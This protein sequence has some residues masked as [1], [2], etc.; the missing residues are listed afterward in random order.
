ML[1]DIEKRLVF[2]LSVDVDEHC[3]HL[4]QERHRRRLSVN[5]AGAFSIGADGA[6]NEQ[7]VILCGIPRLRKTRSCRIGNVGKHSKNLRLCAARAHKIAPHALTEHGV[8][9]VDED[10]FARAR[11]AGQ[12]IK[13]AVKIHI[14]LFNDRYIFNV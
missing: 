13:A 11:F 4:T 2:M 3:P 10:G 1:G 9:G 6:L 8:D 5:A 7:C 12:H 14:S